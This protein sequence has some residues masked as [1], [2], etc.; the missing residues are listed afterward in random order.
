VK[1]SA[2]KQHITRLPGYHLLFHKFFMKKMLRVPTDTYSAGLSTTNVPI[3]TPAG[4]KKFQQNST[5]CYSY[6]SML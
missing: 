6:P 2:I 3:I 5:T 1:L 4:V